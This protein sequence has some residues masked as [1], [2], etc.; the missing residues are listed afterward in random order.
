MVRLK[1]RVPARRSVITAN[2]VV[3]FIVLGVGGAAL[4]PA[5]PW[6]AQHWAIRLDETGILYTML[7][8]ASCLTVILSGILLDRI[9]R[10]PIL[11]TGLL[12]AALGLTGLAAAPSLEWG[13]V[14]AFTMGLGWG[15][16]D[17][18]LN[19]FVADLYPE[20]RNA[21]LNIMNLF[22]GLGSLLG[23]LTIGA[24]LTLA[25]TPSLVLI[26]LSGAALLTALVYIALRFPL[27]P[28]AAGEAP[29]TLRSSLRVLREG[30]VLTLALML[31]LYVGLE[32]G[33]GGWAT[34]FGIQGAHLDAGVAALVPATYWIAFTLSRL[35]AG[36]ISRYV[37]GTWLVLGGAL[38]AAVGALAIAFSAAAPVVLFA[39]AAVLGLGFGPIFPTA[40]GLA[41]A[42][43][44]TVTGAVS[45]IAI[46]GG[47]LGGTVL[48]NIQG[49]LLVEGGVSMAAGF[50]AAL[51]LAVAGLQWALSATRPAALTIADQ[52][53]V[54]I[55]QPC[56]GDVPC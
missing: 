42:R 48:P 20:T 16:L 34:S 12:F 51:A 21:A 50:L 46:L 1:E 54:P 27:A 33:F 11:I 26:S 31:F 30:Y 28:G 43:Y 5:L 40:F 36:L 3:A 22:F 19:V 38:L 47:S 39:G 53:I 9:G 4:G 41:T 10:K 32:I 8:A 14:A 7:F 52:D 25:W 13:M 6:L 45:S 37:P 44:P 29:P 24:A 55:G 23:P 35:G 17:V 2:T 56:P 15:C 49:H 18:T